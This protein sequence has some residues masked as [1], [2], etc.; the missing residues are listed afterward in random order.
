MYFKKCWAQKN[1]INRYPPFDPF[2]FVTKIFFLKIS[3]KMSN[4]FSMKFIEKNLENFLHSILLKKNSTLFR[5]I[6]KKKFL[7]Q[8]KKGGSQQFFQKNPTRPFVGFWCDICKNILK[9]NNQKWKLVRYIQK[10]EEEQGRQQN[11]KNAILLI[12]S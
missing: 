11:L 4:F 10:F 9:K 1:L 6:R 5:K 3:E 7:T 12:L 2:F 8:K